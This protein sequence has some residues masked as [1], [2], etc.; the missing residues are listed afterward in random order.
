MTNASTSIADLK[1]LG[2]ASTEWLEA[3]GICTKTDLMRVGPV[4]AFRM[5]E[6]AR[7]RPALCDGSGDHRCKMERL[8]NDSLHGRNVKFGVSVDHLWHTVVVEPPDERKVVSFRKASHCHLRCLFNHLSLL[9][10]TEV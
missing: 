8:A 4:V 7:F 2:P 10:T 1:N 5:V 3:V 9:I 6:Q